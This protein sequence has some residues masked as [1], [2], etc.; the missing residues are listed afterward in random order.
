MNPNVGPRSRK[1]QVSPVEENI[2]ILVIV[3]HILLP[4]SSGYLC[5]LIKHM[6]YIPHELNI[7]LSSIK[8]IL[9]TYR[10]PLAYFPSLNCH[11]SKGRPD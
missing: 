4:D 9:Y 3:L 2:A 8:H 1:A 11:L 7:I 10:I 6:K 5:Y